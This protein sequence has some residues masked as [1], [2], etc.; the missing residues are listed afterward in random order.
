MRYFLMVL[1]ALLLLGVE[2]LRVTPRIIEKGASELD[3]EQLAQTVR[4]ATVVALIVSAV[5]AGAAYASLRTLQFDV[6]HVIA[7]MTLLG[8]AAVFLYAID[9]FVHAERA[10]ADGR[11]AFGI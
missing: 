9:L 8:F 10:V 6:E 5:A 3:R 4:M 1:E 7:A 11:E 2:M